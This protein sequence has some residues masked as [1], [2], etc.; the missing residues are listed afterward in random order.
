MA[1]E[2]MQEWGH[3]IIVIDETVKVAKKFLEND[4][5]FLV[6]KKLKT[7]NNSKLA[8]GEDIADFLG[9]G[10]AKI[11]ALKILVIDNF[12]KS[13]MITFL[14]QLTNLN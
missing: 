6:G 3:S 1:N 8:S 4:S 5:T 11:L 12:I 13:L 9:W 2:N 14:I 10:K 7:S